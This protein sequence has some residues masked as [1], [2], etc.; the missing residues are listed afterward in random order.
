MKTL[1]QS[2]QPDQCNYYHEVINGCTKI[3]FDVDIKVPVE[4]LASEAVNDV[5]EAI[6]DEETLYAMQC[7][8]LHGS[9]LEQCVVY[10]IQRSITKSCQSTFGDCIFTGP[11]SQENRFAME[12]LD[13]LFDKYRCSREVVDEGGKFSFKIS[14]HLVLCPQHFCMTTKELKALSFLIKQVVV[15]E[16]QPLFIAIKSDCP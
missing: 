10:L 4:A 1:H 7:K 9:S 5:C 6:T 14:W 8:A 13:C 16:L 15:W 12:S 11:P 3:F 2:I